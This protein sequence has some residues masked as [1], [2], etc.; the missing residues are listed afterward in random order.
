[1]ANLFYRGLSFRRA[2]SVDDVLRTRTEVVALRQNTARPDRPATGLVILRITTT[3]QH[4]RTVLDFWRCAM[5]PLRDPAVR[6]EWRDDVA[7]VPAPVGEAGVGEWTR[8]WRLTPFQ[9]VLSRSSRRDL[10]AGDSWQVA[11]GDVVSSA[12]SWHS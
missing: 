7:A 6:T 2:P 4:D 9:D 1:M 5:L 11:G 10:V 3:D 12:P 8:S